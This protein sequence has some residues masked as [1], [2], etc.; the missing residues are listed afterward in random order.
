MRRHTQ[1]RVGHRA[2][3]GCSRRWKERVVEANRATDWARRSQSRVSL[4]RRRKGGHHTRGRRGGEGHQQHSNGGW[5]AGEQVAN[6]KEE[7]ERRRGEMKKKRDAGLDPPM[8]RAR[9]PHPRQQQART[10]AR[11]VSRVQRRRV[12]DGWIGVE[13][14]S[15]TATTSVRA[16]KR[17]AQASDGGGR[18]PG[19][20]LLFKPPFRASTRVQQLC[21]CPPT[22]R[23]A[24]SLCVRCGSAGVSTGRVSERAAAA[25]AAA[26]ASQR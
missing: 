2:G 20:R 4:Y 15:D 22:H 11:R 10:H 6:T 24:V 18:G 13:S 17:A 8:T 23:A 12:G 25:A 5:S 7:G 14:P 19:C 21:V 3:N 26:A 1:R 9:A 16:W